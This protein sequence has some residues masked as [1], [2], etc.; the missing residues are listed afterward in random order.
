MAPG[1]TTQAM[2]AAVR[3]AGYFPQFVLDGLHDG[4]AGE[5]VISFATH[6][7]T[8]FAD[9]DIRRHLSVFALTPSRL[10]I[11]HVDDFGPES[12]DGDVPYLERAPY[13]TATTECIPLTRITGVAITRTVANPT[14]YRAGGKVADFSVT[15]SWG[16][17]SR[18]DLDQYDCGNA[19]CDAEHGFTGTITADDVTLHVNAAVD[20]HEA[21]ANLRTFA[22]ALNAAISQGGRA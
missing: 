5:E 22:R 9:E 16:A 12:Q 3:R 6:V 7:E 21:A 14:A 13:A 20:G 19:S 11:E 10:V 17:A 1:S 18:I 2:D 4:I 8:H 15:I